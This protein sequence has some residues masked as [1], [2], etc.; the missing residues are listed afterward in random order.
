MHGDTYIHE[1]NL[2]LE[3][4]RK[5]NRTKHINVSPSM[6]IEEQVVEN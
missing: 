5:R 6:M 2:E 1:I 4:G 3:A